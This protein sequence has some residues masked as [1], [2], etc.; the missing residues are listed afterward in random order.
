VLDTQGKLIKAPSDPALWP[1][2]REELA[3][4]RQQTRQALNYDDSLYG[5]AEFRWS[6]SNYA[7]GFVMMYDSQFYDA[8]TGQYTVDAVLEEG[9]QQFGGYDSVVLWHAY[10]RIGFDARNQY[11]FYR[12]MPGGLVGVCAVVDA[13]HARGVKVYIY[14]N[15]WDVGTRR[16][17]RP[18]TEM[19][20]EMTRVLDIDGLFL[21]TM[22]HGGDEFRAMLDATRPGVIMQGEGSPPQAQIADHH[23]SWG[24]WCEDSEA[25]GVLRHKWY[26][27]RHMQHQAQRWNGDHS[28]ELHTAWMNG[29][30]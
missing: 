26:E 7:C 25:P 14:Y 19:L 8:A 22:T 21:D 6:A 2:Y 11:D 5:K 4:W 20:A 9:L 17:G 12:D 18:D 29:S 30:G 27:R 28:G 10:P 13:F 16:E 3:R 1:R 15:P 24:Q 23:A